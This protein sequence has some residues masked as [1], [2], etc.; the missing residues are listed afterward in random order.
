MKKMIL[1]LMVLFLAVFS[2]WAVPANPVPYKYTQPDGTVITLVNHGDEHFNWTTD[3]N[4]NLMKRGADGFYRPSSESLSTKAAR[5]RARHKE[6]RNKWS[7]YEN[8]PTINIGSPTLLCVLLEFADK[9]S[10]FTVENPRQHFS[11]MLNQEGYSYNGAIG[12]VRDYYIDNSWGQFK[13]SFVVYGPVR[14]S[15]KKAYYSDSAGEYNDPK[16]SEA[17][18]EALNKL[19]ENGTI[20]DLTQFDNDKDGKL[21]MILCYYAGR[22]P[23]EGGDNDNPWPHQNEAYGD[24]GGMELT[25]Y[26]CSSELRG[27][28]SCNEAANIGITCH[29]FAH[30]L[31][32]PD[33]YD[34]NRKVDGHSV[35]TTG[36]YDVM[37][38]GSALDNGRRPVYLSVLERNMLGWSPAPEVIS[39]SGT[40]SLNAVQTGSSSHNE[41]FYMNTEN[42]G[43]Y[44]ILEYRNGNKWDSS[45]PSGLLVYHIDRSENIVQENKTAKYL[46]EST[47]LIN[48]FGKHPCYRLFPTVPSPELEYNEKGNYYTAKNMEE[49]IFPGCH[50]ATGVVPVDWA[51]K[52]ARV[53]LSSIACDGTRSTFTVDVGKKMVYGYVRTNKGGAVPGAQMVLSQSAHPFSTARVGKTA[54]PSLL[55]TDKTTTTDANGFYSFEVEDT[56]PD[57]LIVTARKDGFVSQSLNVT[58]NAQFNRT[59]FTL[60]LLGEGGKAILQRYDATKSPVRSSIE[61]TSCAVGFYY[62]A[63]ELAQMK[64]GGSVLESVSINTIAHPSDFEKIYIIADVFVGEKH[65]RLLEKDITEGYIWDKLITIDVSGAHIT[66]PEGAD[67]YIGYGLSGYKYGDPSATTTPFYVAGPEE[68]P[69]S[70]NYQVMDFLNSHNW[71]QTD[72]GAGK[73]YSYLV[74]ANLN[75]VTT[76][77][78]ASRGISYIFLSEGVPTVAPA[79]GKTVLDITWTLDGKPVEGTPSAVSALSPGSHTYMARI[80]YYDGTAERVYYDIDAK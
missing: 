45:L 5:V 29:E 47:N 24:V 9:D 19:Y 30:A 69:T 3:I 59:D 7:S 55:P 8:H 15:G 23:A 10:R 73:Y 75:L 70:G 28:V 53:K 72:W 77:D 11:D 67:L 18:S 1:S 74:S 37:A 4:G 60:N 40:Y 36:I 44:F 13:P 2:V 41:G 56:D 50:A 21:D 71:T 62:S 25:Q 52:E 34:T 66:I 64:A 79:A 20:T 31:G 54:A 26:F 48:A 27:D 68:G 51:G 32:L 14:V 78:F 65:T 57:C 39:Q 42:P 43:E 16:V 58:A 22:N 6:C 12:S 80:R 38:E 46:W 49:F 17:I 61:G 35:W 33:F 76:P 63:Q